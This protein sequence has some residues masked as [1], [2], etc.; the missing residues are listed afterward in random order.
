MN[1]LL[2]PSNVMFRSVQRSALQLRL[3]SDQ[4][5][6]SPSKETLLMTDWMLEGLM[7]N[8]FKSNLGAVFQRMT[9]DV[10]FEDKIFGYKLRGSS[11][12]NFHLM[13]VRAYFR[14]KSPYNKLEYLGSVV[15]EDHEVLTIL[16]R[17]QS[18]K[19]SFMRYFPTFVTGK[20]QEYRKW[21]GAMDFY[22]Q[23]DGKIYKMINRPATD[24]DREAALKLSDLKRLS[25]Q[26]AEQKESKVAD[27]KLHN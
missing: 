8:F 15:Y 14:Y 7:P 11:D 10:E 16:W 21:E 22:V 12:L 17:L 2:R 18:L 20:Q 1:Y 4:K 25:T 26:E 23:S 3:L 6:Q 19:S 9:R 24:N 13:K 27:K 5:L